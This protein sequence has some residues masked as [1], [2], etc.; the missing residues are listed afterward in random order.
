MD[1][2][3]SVPSVF[4]GLGAR[5][6]PSERVA[7]EAIDAYL[8]HRE[9]GCPVDPHAAD[10]LMLPLVFAQRQSAYRVSAI[11]QHLLTQRDI[12]NRFVSRAIEIAGELGQPGEVK[13][14]S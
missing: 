4:Y 10:Q 12:I 11:T 1:Y 2:R 3:G 7:D 9:T 5:G 13:I 14:S 8:A 6:K